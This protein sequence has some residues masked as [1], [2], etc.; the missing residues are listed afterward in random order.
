[1]SAGKIYVEIDL[2]SS[3]LKAG[4]K[5]VEA[6]SKATG[7][8]IE[9][10]YKAA[11]KASEGAFDSMKSKASEA[12]D[13]IKKDA[14]SAAKSIYEDIKGGLKN[15]YDDLKASASASMSA[16]VEAIKK[17]SSETWEYLKSTA[18][19]I[20]VV[21]ATW[22]AFG[23]TAAG[24]VSGLLTGVGFLYAAYKSLTFA[25]GLFTGSSYKSENIDALIAE[26]KAVATLSEQMSVS[27]TTAQSYKAAMDR[28]GVSSTDV[29]A[30]YQK[31]AI[32]VR[33]NTEELDR[34]G[35][36]YKDSNGVLLDQ[37]TI[38]ENAND[39][40]DS[41]TEG[42]D[43]DQAATAIAMGTQSQIQA[44]LR[45]T[46][47]ELQKS[48]TR[49]DDY[50]LG[51]GPET[52]EAVDDYK[53]AMLE[54]NSETK[55]MSDGFT[56][57]I[58]DQIM[59][60]FTS[61]SKMFSGGWPIIVDTFRYSAATI[62]SL[63]WGLVTFSNIVIDAYKLMYGSVGDILF[64]ISQA[65]I[66]VMQGDFLGAKNSLLFIW[67]D[68]KTRTSKT[69][70]SIVKDT[71]KASNAMSMAW[72]FDGRKVQDTAK[73]VGETWVAKTKEAAE[74]AGKTADATYADMTK[75][76]K[77]HYDAAM[78]KSQAWLANERATYANEAATVKAFYGMEESDARKWYDVQWDLIQAYVVDE[79]KK[80]VLLIGL[81]DEYESKI[82][83]NKMKESAA[84]KAAADKQIDV[85]ASMY[86]TIDEYSDKSVAAEIVALNK[87]YNEL[88][89][90]TDKGEDL[91]DS[92]NKELRNI[93]AKTDKTRMDYYNKLERYGK[94]ADAVMARL[95]N[96]EYDR[97]YKATRDSNL[98]EK[99]KTDFIIEQNLKRAAAEND[100]WAGMKAQYEKDKANLTTWGLAG[101]ETMKA[102][103]TSMAKSFGTF[104]EDVYQ[105]KLKN[106]G[107]Y[108]GAIWDATRQKFFDMVGK[109][110]AE[111][112]IAGFEMSWVGEGWKSVVGV[113][114]KVLGWAGD[115]MDSLNLGD[116]NFMG[117]NYE[118]GYI[119]G[120]AGGGRVRGNALHAGNHPGNDTVM[121]MLSPGEYVIPRTG[122]NSD[123]RE[124]L[125]YIRKTGRA[126]RGYA[127][128]GEVS[129]TWY[130]E[131]WDIYYSN[132]GPRTQMMMDNST[133][134]KVGKSASSNGWDEGFYAVN[135]L[136]PALVMKV[137]GPQWAGS[138][139]IPGYY[140]EVPGT[141][142]HRSP[143]MGPD[144]FE[145]P[146]GYAPLSGQGD[147]NTFTGHPYSRAGQMFSALSMMEP[148]P[149]SNHGTF[150]EIMSMIW[151]NQIPGVSQLNDFL[152]YTSPMGGLVETWQAAGLMS[153]EQADEVKAWSHRAALIVGTYF[154]AGGA[155]AAA[156]AGE[157]GAGGL[158]AADLSWAL[159]AGYTPAEIAALAGS[160]S[161]TAAYVDIVCM[162]N[163][164][165]AAQA[166]D[167][168]L[169]TSSEASAYAS[170]VG[171]LT[172]LYTAAMN[173][174]DPAY[175]S[176]L[177]NISGNMAADAVVN[178]LE[179]T[180]VQKMLGAAVNYF[181]GDKAG[182]GGIDW[183]YAGMTGGDSLKMIP[184]L[185]GIIGSSGT[186]TSARNGL[187]YV[188][189]DNFRAN[190]HE[191]EAVLNKKEATEWREGGL[192]TLHIHLELDGKE[193]GYA[194]AD[195]S[196]TNPRLIKAIRSL[197][198][199]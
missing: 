124:I 36:E 38:L 44:A 21:S 5:E 86:K 28:L 174:A 25:I 18:E 107:D 91:W 43:R 94:D 195:Q 7:A 88:S 155:G 123:T 45:L 70:D 170:Q 13:T 112:I 141:I 97:V 147:I 64:G 81:N 161:S 128:G 160:A 77:A 146:S 92:Y 157:G 83:S 166:L 184:N 138:G 185:N 47:E 108:A 41:Y 191:G 67:D 85:E 32:S 1:M 113:L 57:A 121:A 117:G 116:F 66:K 6:S 71:T 181:S 27:I 172:G 165:S 135:P 39:V 103:S 11:G 125:D 104:F 168:G 109:I 61:L 180:A 20:A 133:W 24:V 15:S 4:Q 69:W 120:Y 53:T 37:K 60:A 76:N 142:L 87:K 12:F 95:A 114:G 197:S 58:A 119:E 33:A 145:L 137:A 100:F 158:S 46:N 167:A 159:E 51:I 152:Y 192:D 48:R 189:R 49:L 54:F 80:N 99:A 55:L 56:R 151:N 42:W 177:G 34:L 130:P 148:R 14:E 31:S 102:M 149:M 188:P 163:K 164:M 193:I 111:K 196:R 89:R 30:A 139:F 176:T 75:A 118:G 26:T 190:L 131:D 169:I 90:F 106:L 129:S 144:G 143:W 173:T 40:L 78:K 22:W 74:A 153:K 79:K 8:A 136:H 126:P 122:V 98:A 50:H 2:D 65:A 72:A 156:G 187:D 134:S 9:S 150:S 84:L 186:I 52:Q 62:T 154:A 63:L 115:W 140:G 198:V 59:P 96:D 3:K 82:E 199:N 23:S 183:S 179:S 29:A 68:L 178:K 194:V 101:I 127:E 110:A 35:V 73:E 19:K 105:G 93:D 162:A 132:L 175:W 171:G 182:G 16:G 10:N 17:Y